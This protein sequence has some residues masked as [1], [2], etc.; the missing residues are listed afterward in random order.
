MMR[1][2]GKH[3]SAGLIR[4]N[5]LADATVP[6]RGPATTD[7]IGIVAIL[8]AT[9]LYNRWLLDARVFFYA[10]DWTWL[11]YAE[12]L[13]WREYL[14]VF[15]TEIYNDRPVG[16]AFIKTLYQIFGLNHF[17]FQSVLLSLHAINC[18]LIY[19]I[20]A[21]Y[22]GRS[23][24]LL[25]AL[26]GAMWFSAL[27]AVGWP[28]AIFDLLG[29]TLC[30]STLLLRQV[31][32]RSS[33]SIGYDLAGAT[34]YLLAVR[35]KEFALGL[36][37]LLVLMN[38]IVER[39]SVRV[40]LKELLPYGVV[41]VVYAF[42]YAR[43]MAT[44]PPASGTAYA[45]D[46]SG[47]TVLSSLGFQVSTAFYGEFIGVIGVTSVIVGLAAA[48]STAG[49]EARR[50]AAFGF[51]GFVIMLGP[52]LLLAT[53]SNT[54]YHALYLYTPH[55]FLALVIGS[56]FGRR[57]LP[58]LVAVAISLTVLVP[59]NWVH[60]RQNVVNFYL[61]MGEVSRAEFFSAV[62]LLAPLPKGATV[63][64]SGVEP[65]LNPFANGPG[66]SLAIAFKDRTLAVVVELLDTELLAKFCEEPGPK[67]FLRFAGKQ[68]SEATA[69]MG[70]RCDR[71]KGG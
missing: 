59:P 63:F 15:P 24:A 44:A 58:T 50:V 39:K 36:V 23:G 25:T 30:F 16:A 52:T 48:L 62:N 57:I 42:R 60:Q 69:E 38:L 64:I 5:P 19:T 18:V 7:W 29:A 27:T 1:L 32:I 67:R 43:L 54:A 71:R 37:V 41:F 8:A 12:F 34:C 17:A 2:R 51:A 49:A 14:R 61:A 26:L 20:A 11:Y 47:S 70:T 9:F 68:G 35:T 46:F 31:A 53:N 13:P 55:F 22:V 33:S 40:T 45:L 65:F 4:A 28:A 21:R 3:C 10:D 6:N 66:K 56:L